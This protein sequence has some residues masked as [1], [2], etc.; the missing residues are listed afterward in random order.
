[1]KEMFRNLEE[2]AMS[3]I[4]GSTPGDLTAAAACAT[5]KA[6]EDIRGYFNGVIND[7][8]VADQLEAR[9]KFRPL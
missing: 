4:R 6:L 5:I 3:S 2:R 9:K 1:M 7:E 8:K